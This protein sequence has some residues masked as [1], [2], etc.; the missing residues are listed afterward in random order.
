MDRLITHK[1]DY[2][3]GALCNIGPSIETN[4][5]FKNESELRKRTKWYN[6]TEAKLELQQ[7]EE[8]RRIM[9]KECINKHYITLKKNFSRSIK[10]NDYGAIEQDNRIDEFIRFLDS[11]GFSVE[12]HGISLIDKPEW[13]DD[14]GRPKDLMKAEYL[15]NKRVFEEYKLILSRFDREK[16]EDASKGFDLTSIPEDGYEFE[17][18]IASSLKIF[19]WQSSVTTAS[20][21][22]GVDVIAEKNS[23]TVGIQ[24]KRYSG[25]VGNKAVQEVAAGRQHFGLDFG[26]VVTT[27]RFTKSADELA[28]T[29]DILLLTVDQLPDLENIIND[30]SNRRH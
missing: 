22:Q 20:G 12:Q 18:W 26:A 2:R 3:Y 8:K 1:S 11:V 28:S 17:N 5:F 16:I 29:N 23:I 30:I 27:S 7:A 15:S 14:D 25:V 4:D 19:G 6:S 21:D 24:C 13:R 10:L 9:L